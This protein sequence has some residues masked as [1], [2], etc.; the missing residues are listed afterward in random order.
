TAFSGRRDGALDHLKVA[1]MHAVVAADGDGDR[2]DR[3]FGKPKV[4]Y[5]VSHPARRRIFGARAAAL[6]RCRL[7]SSRRVWT[8][9][10]CCGARRRL[11]LQPPVH[12]ISRRR[13]R[14]PTF[15]AAPSPVRRSPAEGRYGPAPPGGRRSRALAP[16]Q[17]L[18]PG[19]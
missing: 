1:H 16:A 13:T 11:A 4:S 5:Q 15:S 18:A 7:R 8:N 3:A 17:V 10:L 6:R 2:T 9:T 12:R 19:P 14:V